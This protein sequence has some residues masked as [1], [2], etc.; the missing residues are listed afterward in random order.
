MTVVSVIGEI[1]KINTAARRRSIG[2]IKHLVIHRN[3]LSDDPIAMAQ[4]FRDPS[5]KTGGAFPY[6]FLVLDNETVYQCLP[7][8]KIGEAASGLNTSGIQVCGIGDFRKSPPSSKQYNAMVDLCAL[9]S[10]AANVIV[11][12][13]ELKG[14]SHDPNKVCPGKHLDLNKFR[15]DVESRKTVL[16]RSLDPRSYGIVL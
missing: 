16:P 15:A 14:H 6:H 10:G 11:G 13:T 1:L 2:Q 8:T 9:L 12:H 7:L 5:L 3:A 4:R